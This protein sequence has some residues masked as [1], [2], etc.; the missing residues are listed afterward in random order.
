MACHIAGVKES[1]TIPRRHLSFLL[2]FLNFPIFPF[3]TELSH[4]SSHD[5]LKYYAKFNF[6]KKA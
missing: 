5:I 4:F 3:W 6:V 1:K 2:I